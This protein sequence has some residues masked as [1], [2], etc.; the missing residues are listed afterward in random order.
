[1][2]GIITFNGF[3]LDHMSYRRSQENGQDQMNLSPKFMI[4]KIQSEEDAS[5]FNIVL[6]VKVGGE[7]SALPFEAEV[8]VKGFFTFNSDESIDYEIDDLQKFTLVNGSA[9][10]FP[11][12]RSILTDITSKSNHNPVI[13]PTI[14]FTKFIKEKDLDD[15][16]IDSEEYEDIE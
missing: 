15:M 5:N 3:K 1:M 16:M 12:L 9:I 6:G 4:F 13:L 7:E 2:Q 11:Y 8:I 14:N 10:L